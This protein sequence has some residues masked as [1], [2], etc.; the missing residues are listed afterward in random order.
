MR[1]VITAAILLAMAAPVIACET[2]PRQSFA[3]RDE[4]RSD[5]GAGAFLDALAKAVQAHDADALAAMSAEDVKLDFGGGEGR[6]EL[7]ARLTGGEE[8]YGDLW[9][10]LAILLSLGCASEDKGVLTLPWYFSQDFAPRDPFDTMLAI[11]P[12]VP[13]L[14]KPDPSGEVI[15]RLDWDVVEQVGDYDPEA[16]FLEV[17][18]SD[19][20]RGFVETGALRSLIDYRLIAEETAEGWRIAAFIAGD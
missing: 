4:C 6:D 3:P 15:A 5:A 8:Y 7:R 2:P 11:R 19:Q 20:S 18:L 10:E 17:V 13:L 9:R 16:Q 12:G 14:A 1:G